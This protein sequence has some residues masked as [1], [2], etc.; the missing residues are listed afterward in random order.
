LILLRLFAA[1]PFPNLPLLRTSEPRH[2][3]IHKSQKDRSFQPLGRIATALLE[4]LWRQF[5]Q[6]A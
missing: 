4:M 2:A 3:T 5:A 6:F 1:N